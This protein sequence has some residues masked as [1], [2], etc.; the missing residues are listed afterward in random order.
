MSSTVYEIVVIS[1]S[2]REQGTYTPK[3]CSDIMVG[4]FIRNCCV[5]IGIDP[6]TV[7]GKTLN[8]IVYI[9]DDELWDYNPCQVLKESPIADSRC[10]R[11]EAVDR[12]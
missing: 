2:S 4:E 11:I 9:K 3:V 10:L 5:N 1:S 7:D 8:V 6:D 12:K